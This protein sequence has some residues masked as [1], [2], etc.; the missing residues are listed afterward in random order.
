MELVWQGQKGDTGAINELFTRY[1]PR[2]QR[3]LNIKIT[4]AQRSLVD[5]D[6]VLQE[7]LIVAA[8]R[9][10]EL[11]VRTPSSI[12]QWL[13]RIAEYEIKNRLE[14]LHAEKRDLAREQRARSDGDS[15]DLTGV[16][17]PSGDPTPSQ[18]FAR[19]EIEQLID[20]HVKQLE[21]PDY[22]EV[23]LL[24][25]YFEADWEGIRTV[26]GRRTVQAVQELY[27]RAQRRLRERI[28]RHLR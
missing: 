6:D 22:R 23:I 2:L 8:R 19:T 4:P 10:S 16:V 9:L 14:Y 27:Q 11:E 3:I 5:P 17:V 28:A 13:S 12:L 18:D 25:D 24:R 20:R 7:T 1:I 26:L 21:P 15:E